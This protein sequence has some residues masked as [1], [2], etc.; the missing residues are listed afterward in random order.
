VSTNHAPA[1]RAYTVIK[2]E[3]A[4]DYWLAIGAAWPTKGEGL[5]V[6]LQA[7]P[8]PDADGVLKIVL[9]RPKDNEAADAADNVRSI[10]RNKGGNGRQPRNRS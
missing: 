5:N 9:R 1:L 7:M 10:D 3:N 8:L 6:I 4:D 2:R